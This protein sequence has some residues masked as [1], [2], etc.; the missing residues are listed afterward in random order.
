MKVSRTTQALSIGL[1]ATILLPGFMPV[2]AENVKPQAN[3]E[4]NKDDKKQTAPADKAQGTPVAPVASPPVKIVTGPFSEVDGRIVRTERRIV[5]DFETGR[6]AAVESAEFHKALD[7]ITEIEAQ[8]RQEPG[9]FTRWQNVRMNYLLD[10]LS[11]AI[12]H[13]ERDREVGVGPQPPRP[14]GGGRHPR[15]DQG[16]RP[17][18][19]EALHAE[20]AS[21]RGE[22]L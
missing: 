2:I 14:G 5:E 12:D 16:G 21:R 7:H 4:A 8:F 1:M 19:L 20:E 15:V 10:K 9:K 11:D 17:R 18:R 6:L 3:S 22:Q 13:A